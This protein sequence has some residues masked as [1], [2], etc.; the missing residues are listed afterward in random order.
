MQLTVKDRQSLPDIALLALG[1]L[2]GAFSL[3]VRNGL[4]VTASLADGQQI[5]YELEDVVSDAVRSAYAL[6]RICPATDIDPAEY[7]ELLYATGT[8]RPLKKRVPVNPE[9]TIPDKLDEVL[10][11]LEKGETIT[12]ESPQQFTRIFQ[13][14][15]SEVFS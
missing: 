8:T 2:A 13:D 9:T 4:S 6:Q 11:A 3:A 10:D 15:F 1:S 14:P 7:R 5:E 12:P